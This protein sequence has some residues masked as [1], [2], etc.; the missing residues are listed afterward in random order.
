MTGREDGLRGRRLLV[1]EDEPMVAMLLEDLLMQ[2]G[3]IVVGP[4]ATIAEALALLRD[5]AID[6]A[7][8]D[9][10]LGSELIYPLADVLRASG[11]PFV[12]VTGYAASGLAAGYEDVAV[13]RKPFD[14]SAFPR[15]VAAALS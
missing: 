1:V 15:N 7:L 12:F 4:A 8:L 10:N 14:P 5:Q 3:C 6:G 2:A 9:V 11:T 13:I